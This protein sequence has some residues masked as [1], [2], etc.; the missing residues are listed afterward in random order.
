MG[1]TDKLLQV[2]NSAD[3]PN[4]AALPLSLAS[5]VIDLSVNRDLGPGG[6][7]WLVAQIDEPPSGGGGDLVF[8]FATVIGS[9]SDLLA[10]GNI[11]QQ[12]GL[13]SAVNMGGSGG[14]RIHVA[15]PPL[16]DNGGRYLGLGILKTGTTN[17]AVRGKYSAWLTPTLRSA[18]KYYAS[19]FNV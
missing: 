10:S 3:L 17:Y 15:V 16:P 5:E 8:T 1:Y 11:V 18:P 14:V 2:A 4:V 7:L 13:F 12:S 9:T 19:G 6:S